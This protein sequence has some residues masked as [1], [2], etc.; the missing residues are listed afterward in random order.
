MPKKSR[1]PS[2]LAFEKEVIGQFLMF[3]YERQKKKPST[4]WSI[5][6]QE[7][8]LEFRKFID[9]PRN[10]S[11]RKRIPRTQ[12]NDVGALLNRT[13]YLIDTPVGS[14]L[15]CINFQRLKE[16]KEIEEL[17][18]NFEQKLIPYDKTAKKLHRLS[19]KACFQRTQSLPHF[20][21]PISFLELKKKKFEDEAL[22]TSS[23][24]FA[25]YANGG[26]IFTTENIIGAMR[27]LLQIEDVDM[28]DKYRR[29]IQ[30]DVKLTQARAKKYS[31]KV[32]RKSR[33]IGCSNEALLSPYNVVLI[34]AECPVI[35][36]L[37]KSFLLEFLISGNRELKVP[38]KTHGPTFSGR[39]EN[40]Y[41]GTVTF[42]TEAELPQ[43]AN[44]PYLIIF[45]PARLTLRYQYNALEMLQN[46][47]PMMKRFLFPDP[48]NTP[49]TPDVRLAFYNKQ[50]AANPEQKQAVQ[51]IVS[52]SK[53]G[54]IPAPFIIF[55]PP[56]T[57]KTSIIVES[58]LQVLLQIPDAKVLV[59]AGPN[60]AC[61]EIALRICTTLA[62]GKQP[63]KEILARVYC[64][65]QERRRE[66]INKLLLEYSNMYDWHF[67]PD[68]ELL[69]KYRVVVCTL[70]AVGKLTTGSLQQFSHVFLD[71]AAACSMS[72]ALV[73]L[74]GVLN[75]KS[76]LVIAGDHM[77]LGA[78]LNSKRAEELGLGTSLM[79]R[80][81]DRK[82]YNIA[83]VNGSYDQRIQIRLC[84]NFRSHPAIVNLF[85]SL[86]YEN[87]LQPMADAEETNWA[88]KWQ[89]LQDPKFPIIF[90]AVHGKEEVDPESGS[91]SNWPEIKVVFDYVNNL[92]E[93]GLGDGRKLEE[94]DIGIIT[95]YRSQYMAIQEELNAARL[96]QI[97]A[98]SVET[99]RGKEK[100][101]I[102]A[103]FVRSKSKGLGFLSNVK[104]LN[105][106]L[107][108]AKALLILVGNDKKL[109]ENR[110]Y[111][112][113]IKQCQSRGHFI[114]A[115]E[116]SKKQ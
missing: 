20:L 12:I 74:M 113:V 25:D 37:S 19:D 35:K 48:M 94:T 105:V 116:A 66:N 83:E 115:A 78:I 71:E 29:L 102:I 55:G 97:E 49:A 69:K 62:L 7:V 28:L 30:R 96:F 63:R 60:C 72:E 93:K 75:E 89:F 41:N 45:Y 99:Y 54:H 13:D 111:E 65:S 4:D 98:G 110:N 107:S 36:S 80:L 70:G 79:Q 56:G 38:G 67:F 51:N 14:D 11:L 15:F 31:L 90:H 43:V 17:R 61:D 40:I 24:Q 68:V 95:P 33:K 82:C 87:K 47:M 77:Q 6:K 106:V 81:L 39:I 73:G 32:T 46:N 3:L 10:G 27:L 84:R 21:P 59:T 53:V 103:S 23:P 18:L 57:G 112:F 34:V 88:A 76:K 114:L 42:V 16:Y 92:L 9:L 109:C 101:I 52:S 58:I 22:C 100:A 104:R 108:R 26:H 1:K 50:I 8:R 5:N 86:Y 64:W 91:I 85:S 2:T 44:T